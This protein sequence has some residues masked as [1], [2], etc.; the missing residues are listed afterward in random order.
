MTA[1]FAI[2]A[3]HPHWPHGLT[4]LTEL[5][6]FVDTLRLLSIHV[7][8]LDHVSDIGVA[9]ELIIHLVGVV[10]TETRSIIMDL[11]SF[12]FEPVINAQLTELE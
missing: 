10:V 5:H 9:L 2:G 7:V 3:F 1:E 11:R 12:E 4:W 6:V 8:F